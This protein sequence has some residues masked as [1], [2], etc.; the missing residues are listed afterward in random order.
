[1]EFR[2]EATSSTR[3]QFESIGRLA[4]DL[5][6]ESRTSADKGTEYYEA[7]YREQQIRSLANRV[8]KL[9]LQL[10]IPRLRESAMQGFGK[11]NHDFFEEP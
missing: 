11:V 6:V 3:Q 4:D 5:V 7:R 1:L 10:V 9:S 8:Q 2:G